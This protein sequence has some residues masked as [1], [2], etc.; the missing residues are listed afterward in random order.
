LLPKSSGDVVVEVA[1]VVCKTMKLLVDRRWH[2]RSCVR[3]RHVIVGPLCA[4]Q[5][6][7]HLALHYRTDSQEVLSRMEAT[8]TGHL[9]LYEEE[10]VSVSQYSRKW[11]TDEAERRKREI[12]CFILFNDVSTLEE[13]YRLRMLK[14]RVVRRIF[15]P[16]RYEVTGGWRKLHNE[17]LH[18]LYFRQVLLKL[19]SQ[20]GCDGQG[21]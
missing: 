11:K 5:H 7:R 12:R 2:E 14:N 4:A 3:R 17:E 19:S 20:G 8:F 1:A 10:G 13:E 16:S 6:T 18:S 9:N 15:G 21:M